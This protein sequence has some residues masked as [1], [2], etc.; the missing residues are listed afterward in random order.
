[1]QELALR[2]VTV[3]VYL[4]LS[5]VVMMMH[6]GGNLLV[7]MLLTLLMLLKLWRHYGCDG[8]VPPSFYFRSF[9]HPLLFL[10][11]LRLLLLEHG[12]GIHTL[13]A[14]AAGLGG[15]GA[16]MDAA[17]YAVGGGAAYI[18]NLLFLL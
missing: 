9:R 10:T 5:Q 12:A 18:G 6:V 3:A 16:S 4:R 2:L 13:A 17:D 15:K 7:E 11:F 1:L 14:C 8:T